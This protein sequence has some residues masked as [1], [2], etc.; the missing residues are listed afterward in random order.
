[1]YN[2]SFFLQGVA[3]GKYHGALLTNNGDW[4]DYGVQ[5]GISS[6]DLLFPIPYSPE[7]HFSE[8]SSAIADMKNSVGVRSVL[9][10]L[11]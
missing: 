5:A 10:F 11:T 7:L 1:M 8:F 9:L 2:F 4:E 3:T 6:G